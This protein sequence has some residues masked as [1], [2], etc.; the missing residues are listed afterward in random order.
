M[1]PFAH[2]LSDLLNRFGWELAQIRVE[3][4]EWW[5]DEIWELRSVW[6]PVGAC[7]FV[8]LLVDPMWEGQRRKGQ[9]VWAAGHSL[10]DPRSRSEAESG[11]T[12][13]ARASADQMN[14]FVNAISASRVQ[15]PVDGAV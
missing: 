12:L 1:P 2:R 7:A 14:A 11:G 13:P 4:L 6:S 15:V 8:T 5:A 10:V 3:E 9:G